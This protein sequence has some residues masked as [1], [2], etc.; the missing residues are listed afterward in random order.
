MLL[1][2]ANCSSQ[3]STPQST[4]AIE[5]ASSR[6]AVA[7]YEAFTVVVTANESKKKYRL[8][9]FSVGYKGYKLG[10]NSEKIKH[11][12]QNHALHNISFNLFGIKIINKAPRGF[13]NQFWDYKS[14][15]QYRSANVFTSW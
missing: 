5:L 6:T 11:A 3:D 13:E 7:V 2:L 9:A 8:G 1:L 4:F 10:V 15:F 14:Y 12:I